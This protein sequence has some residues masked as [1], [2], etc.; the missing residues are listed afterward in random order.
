MTMVRLLA[1]VRMLCGT[2]SCPR[3]IIVRQVDW[4][5][6]CCWI[7]GLLSRR[8][9]CFKNW[10]RLVSLSQ[11]KTCKNV[12]NSL[13]TNGMFRIVYSNKTQAHQISTN[14]RELNFLS[15]FLNSSKNGLQAFHMIFAI[16]NCVT[17][18]PSSFLFA[19]PM[20]WTKNVLIIWWTT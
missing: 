12:M 17:V 19:P 20:L 9:R 10:F 2:N 16:K 4:C 13:I 3:E 6:A 11:C 5:S 7:W 18:Y 15:M 8:P 14:V 1:W